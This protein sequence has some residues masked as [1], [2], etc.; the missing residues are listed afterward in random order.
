[1]M[2]LSQAR[3]EDKELVWLCAPNCVGSIE[4]LFAAMWF[5]GAA[6]LSRALY[7]ERFG[8]T[9]LNGHKTYLQCILMLS[10]VFFFPLFFFVYLR[11]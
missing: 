8:T 10:T 9:E 2:D 1:M 7:T 5:L 11:C 3:T 4:Q 6:P